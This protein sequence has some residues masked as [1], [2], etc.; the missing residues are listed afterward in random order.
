M[1]LLFMSCAVAQQQVT[2][3]EKMAPGQLGKF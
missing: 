1:Y 2:L 3:N